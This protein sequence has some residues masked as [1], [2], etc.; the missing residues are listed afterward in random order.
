MSGRLLNVTEVK[1]TLK[2]GCCSFLSLFLSLVLV[3]RVIGN[4]LL[5]YRPHLQFFL[6]IL[7]YAAC[8]RAFGFYLYLVF[9]FSDLF[10][11]FL[12]SIFRNASLNIYYHPDN[13]SLCVCV[14]GRKLI[15]HLI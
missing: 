9:A 6:F 14:C 4:S 13:I 15:S 12:E 10:A 1:A 2:N 8:K 7:F 11:T 3:G 5:M